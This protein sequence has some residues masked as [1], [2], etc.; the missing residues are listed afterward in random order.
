MV[1]WTSLHSFSSLCVSWAPHRLSVQEYVEREEVLKL[2]AAGL[3]KVCLVSYFLLQPTPSSHLSPLQEDASMQLE[4]EK[5]ERERNLHIRELKRIQ[6][7]DY[8]RFK[9]HLTLHSRYLL[10]HLIGRGGFSEV[11]KVQQGKGRRGERGRRERKEGEG[12]GERGRREREEREKGGRR[13]KERNGSDVALLISLAPSLQ[14]FD[15]QD[16]R[17]V[18]CKIHQLNSEWKEGKKA[19]YIK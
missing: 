15:L 11:F 7:E 2:R 10:L 18:A 8:S 4:L 3:K 16:Q 6:A 5:L 14:A 19:N 1:L 17:Y 12:G 9:S 13:R